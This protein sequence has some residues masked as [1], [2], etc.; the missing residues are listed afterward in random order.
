MGFCHGFWM[1]SERARTTPVGALG[2]SS[3]DRLR[4]VPE[5]V[6]LAKVTVSY[7]VVEGA[8]HLTRKY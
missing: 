2:L 8:S 6:V 5:C 7:I 3:Q 1:L 4:A